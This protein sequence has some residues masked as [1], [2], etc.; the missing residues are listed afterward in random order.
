[1]EHDTI[2]QAETD[3]PIH[4]LIAQRWSPYAFDGRAVKRD[5]LLSCLEAARWA[6]SSYNEQPW[7]FIVAEREDEEA[8]QRMLS[9]LVEANQGWAQH[10]GVLMLG[11]VKRHFAKNNK[12]NR[13]AEHD[14]G[15]AAATLTF[16][17]SALGLHV[18]QMAGINISVARQTYSVPEGHEPWTG[19][20]LGY[21]ADAERAADEKFVE[22]DRTPRRRE[23]MSKFVFREEWE[24]PA[25]WVEG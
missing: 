4:E 11:V 13:V 21:A 24:Q 25:P 18:H 17:A 5:K 19:I 9:C 10:A 8:F 23:P 2:K 22:R 6:P 12:P 14:L 3:H 16:Q 20:A 7:S 1:M 15:L